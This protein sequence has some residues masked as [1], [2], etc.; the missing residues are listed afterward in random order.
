MLSLDQLRRLARA[1]VAGEPAEREAILAEL[2]N[3]SPLE[4][5]E[6]AASHFQSEDRNVRVAMLR[7]VAFADG[8]PAVETILRGLD[9]PFRRVRNVA[10]KSSCRLTS[11]PR[12][13]ERLQRAVEEDDRGAA[14][15]AFQILSGLYGS[16]YG[17][18]ATRQSTEALEL[19]LQAGRYRQRAL[20]ALLRSPTSEAARGLL[21]KIVKEGTKDEAV[22]AS[23]RL[24]GWRV[25]RLEEFPPAARRDIERTCE[26]AFGQVW[27]WVRDE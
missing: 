27:Y 8:P 5:A 26:R 20:A 17:I 18:R 19:L 11:D 13:L 22:A 9:D 1:N 21:R 7:V 15:P 16:P 12:I 10:A 24:S 4:L 23:R 6:A 2:G 14:G 25:A 3:P